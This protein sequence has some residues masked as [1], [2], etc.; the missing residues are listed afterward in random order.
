MTAKNDTTFNLELHD[1][2]IAV[3]T[4]DLPGEAQNVLKPEFAQEIKEIIE[5]L[6]QDSSIKGLIIRS[7]K[8]G[9]FIAGADISVLKSVETAEQAEQIA[10]T[11][12][13]MFQQLENLKFPVV[14]AI[15]GACL[16]GGLELTLACKGRVATDSPKTK[17]GLP[18]VQLGLLPGSGGTQRLPR[19]IGITPALDMMLTG[20]QLFPKQALKLGLVDEVVPAANL[21]KAARKRVTELSKGEQ[22]KASMGSWF[23]AKGLQ[24]LALETNPIGRNVLFDQAKKQ[25]LKKTRGNYPAPEKILECVEKGVNQGQ[26]AGYAIEAKNFGDLVISSQAKALISIFFATTELKKDSGVD[27]DAEAA[28]VDKVGVLGGGLMGSGIAYV[29]ADKA[30]KQVRVKDISEK[31]INGALNYSW[32]LINKKLKRRILSD[33]QAKKII[34]RLTGSTDYAGFKDCD[35]VIE[36]V[37]E[38]LKLKHQMVNDVEEN[39][40]E[41]TIFATNT[42]SIPITDIAQA[43]K[44]P[45]QVVGLHYFSPVEKMPLLEI[46]TTD[47]T[48]DWVVATCVELG[49]QQGKTP[50]VVNDGAGFYVNRILAPYMNEAGLLLS[51]GVAVEKL[52]S[53]LVDAGFPVGPITLLDEVGIDVATKVAPILQDAFGERMAPPKAFDKLLEDDRKGRKNGR[54]FYKY[55][56]A[57]KGKKEVDESVYRVLGVEPTKH[58]DK[59]EIVERGILLMANEAALCLEE[60]II[61]SARDGDIGAIFG[62][63][64]PPFHGGPFRYMDSLGIDKVVERLEYYKNLYGERFTPAPI[65][66][67]IKDN[68]ETFHQ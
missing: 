10:R 17:L 44:R 66:L 7:G 12:Q 16:G 32:K 23:S 11:G 41:K 24:K 27:S 28:T 22:K 56:K 63:G 42:S 20:K 61:R 36:A 1:D 47:K 45:E 46:I 49:K 59:A 39:C 19:L 6:S 67:K 53:A 54:G 38:D 60:G 31:G 4:I 52:D 21:M 37:F 58:V 33:S 40:S 9:S 50:I 57:S 29:S 64:F 15:D 14:A 26:A 51:E 43:A 5:P 18:E 2:G 62:I 35:M 13:Q 65:L 68:S 34:S 25:L 8:K 30:G 3:I 55:D 48:A